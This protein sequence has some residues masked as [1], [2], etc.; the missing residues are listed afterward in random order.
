MLVCPGFTTKVIR[1]PKDE[2][3]QRSEEVYL[4]EHISD[5]EDEQDGDRM[6]VDVAG[7]GNAEI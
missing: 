1:D 7:S 5:N 3:I 2:I 6:I 4:G